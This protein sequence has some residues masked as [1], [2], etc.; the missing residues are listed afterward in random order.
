MIWLIGAGQMAID[1]ANV[2]LEQKRE[3]I[4]I[5]RSERSAKVFLDKTGIS[6]KTGSLSKWISQTPEK[7]TAAIVAVNVNK[8]AETT[9]QLLNYG[10]KKILLEK[11]GGVNN[12]E[13]LE[14]NDKSLKLNGEIHIA[15]NRR[16]YASTLAAQ[17]I[18]MNDGGVSSFNFEFTEWSHIIENIGYPNE[19]MQQ[20]FLVN[21]SHVVNLSF[22]L[23]GQPKSW[24]TF[25]S[26]SL[27]WHSNASNFA[28]AGVSECGALFS[29]QANWEAP[30]RWGVEI[31]T[32]KHRL[33]FRPMEK[34]EIQEKGSIKIIPVEIDYTLDSEYKPG[35]YLQTECFFE[36][37]KHKNNLC[38]LAEH[39]NSLETYNKML[40]ASTENVR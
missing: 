16:F 13:I 23:G 6:V 38:S 32:R 25:T 15:Y 8:L 14:L 12:K 37:G 28:G 33:Y 18:I 11:P 1:Y 40:N 10:V 39:C 4:V 21:S 36:L 27:P 19:V 34:L 20:W 3:F 31:L 22:F 24:S 9:S 7:P 29:Y 2:L 30:G 17:E 5:G 35:L 26:G